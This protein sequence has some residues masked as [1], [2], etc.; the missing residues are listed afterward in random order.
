MP[1]SGNGRLAIDDAIAQRIP[2]PDRLLFPDVN[3]RRR[4]VVAYYAEVGPY[5]IEWGRGRKLTLKRYPHGIHSRAFYQK[6]TPSGTPILLYSV[7]DLLDWVGRGALEFHAPLGLV[8]APRDH[9]WAILDL[10]PNPPAGWAD[11]IAVA[12][13]VIDLLVLL[14]VPYLMK[15]SGQKGL[16]FYLPIEPCAE[17]IVLEIMR[18]LAELVVEVMPQQATL[19]RLKRDRGA[20]VYLDYLQNGAERTT[21]MPYSVRATATAT[22]SMPIT[23]QELTRAPDTWTVQ[24]VLQALQDDGPRF[25]WVGPRIDLIHLARRHRLWKGQTGHGW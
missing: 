19:A 2:H 12:R 6:H 17:D 1:A 9:D 15:T 25:H 8:D 18:A 22:V 21:V 3:I 20:R 11:V 23:V 7:A 14:D 24:T 5:L 4:D 16:H 10:D 13:A